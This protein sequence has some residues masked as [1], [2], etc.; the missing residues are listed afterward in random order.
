MPALPTPRQTH[1]S[2]D[3]ELA[4]QTSESAPGL[5]AEGAEASEGQAAGTVG[6]ATGSGPGAAGEGEISNGG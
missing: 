3:D 6:Q 5:L 2:E 1:L 4:E